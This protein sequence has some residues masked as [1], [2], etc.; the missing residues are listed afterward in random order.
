MGLIVLTW[1]VPEDV[2][3]ERRHV[4][5]AIV[6]TLRAFLLLAIQVLVDRGS[7]FSERIDQFKEITLDMGLVRA[8]APTPCSLCASVRAV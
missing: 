2:R 7:P 3:E 4:P 8:M 5:V 1:A 6:A